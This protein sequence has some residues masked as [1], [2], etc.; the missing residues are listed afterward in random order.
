[1]NDYHVK[2]LHRVLKEANEN[3]AIDDFGFNGAMDSL[4]NIESRLIELRD[5]RRIVA[6][7]HKDATQK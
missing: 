6:K 5:L 1:M 2:T 4:Y 7:S 3:G